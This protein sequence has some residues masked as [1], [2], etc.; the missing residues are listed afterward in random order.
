MDSA[1]RPSLAKTGGGGLIPED[2]LRTTR[3][4]AAL[5]AAFF[6]FLASDLRSL[7]LAAEAEFLSFRLRGIFEQ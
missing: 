5:S 2:R 6:S 7:V 1:S 4:A 3:D